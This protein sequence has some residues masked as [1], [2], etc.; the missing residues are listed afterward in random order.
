MYRFV[1]RIH[2]SDKLV[3]VNIMNGKDVIFVENDFV[4]LVQSV[5]PSFHKW[6]IHDT[7]K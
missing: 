7:M 3:P 6:I 5:E 2:S 1:S 4:A